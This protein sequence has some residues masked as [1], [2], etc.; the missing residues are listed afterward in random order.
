LK[1]KV[2]IVGLGQ[3]GLQ[4]DLNVNQNEYTLTHSHAFSAHNSFD[5]LGAVDIDKEQRN[6][7]FNKYNLPT[8]CSLDE[9]LKIHDP[10]I[11]VISTETSK[12]ATLLNKILRSSDP[13]IIVCEKPLSYSL[14]E[15]Q[16]MVDLCENR[17]IIL[18]VNYIRRS[19]PGVIEIKK[20]IESSKFKKD[21][22]GICWY[23]KG[24]IHNGSHFFNLLTYWL[25]PMMQFNLISDNKKRSTQKDYEP[26]VEVEF[27]KGKILFLSAWEEYFS[28][29]TI[30]LLSPNGRIRYDNEGAKIQF[31]NV[32]EDPVFKGYKVLNPKSIKIK[33]SM[34]HY[35]LN[36]VN[37]L[38]EYLNGN[39]S[40]LCSGRDALVTLTSMQK[41]I[42]KIK[43]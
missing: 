21:Y 19:D 25:G 23:S 24:F 42:N 1:N 33:T 31:Q 13:K 28:H 26:D 16:T 29:Y 3:I 6:I 7:F 43:K 32:I 2:L 15:A 8:Y 22:K 4:Y 35:Q 9:A 17:G 40:Y 37:Q 14:A 34:E 10:D 38:D 36:V 27:E 18:F 39:M 30:E 12:H 41:I 11:I 5:L 20:L